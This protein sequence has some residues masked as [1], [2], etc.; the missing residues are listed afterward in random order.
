MNWFLPLGNIHEILEFVKP[1]C[2]SEIINFYHL[3]KEPAPG[4]NRG[5][6]RGI[7]NVSRE[8]KDNKKEELSPLLDYP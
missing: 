2:P 1:F 7:F 5:R 6:L 3:P 4:L 8:V